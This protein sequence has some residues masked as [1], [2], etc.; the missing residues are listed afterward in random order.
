MMRARAGQIGSIQRVADTSCDRRASALRS[1]ARLLSLVPMKKFFGAAARVYA[2][3][4]F[5]ALPLCLVCGLV[6]GEFFKRHETLSGWLA[7]DRPRLVR[8]RWLAGDRVLRAVG[9][10]GRVWVFARA[11]RF[12]RR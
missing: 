1:E 4:L 3:W 8:A 2:V 9:S 11:S 5:I 10:R 7:G 12:G 6:A